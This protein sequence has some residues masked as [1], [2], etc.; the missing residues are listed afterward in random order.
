MLKTLKSNGRTIQYDICGKGLPLVLIHGFAEDNT[1][2]NIQKTYLKEK[3]LVLSI[4]LPGFGGSDP[5]IKNEAE[6][7]DFVSSIKA[8][9]LNE[10]IDTCVMLGHSM[11][12]YVTLAY[13]NAFPGDLLGIGLIH[14]TAGA[15]SQKRMTLRKKSILFIE[16]HGSLAF[17]KTSIPGL[18]HEPY[19]YEK[20]VHSLIEKCANIQGDILIQYY[21]A[22]MKRPDYTELL[23][24]MKIPLLLIAGKNDCI[25]PLKN[26]LCQSHLSNITQF[27]ILKE[28][29]HIGMKEEPKKINQAIDDFLGYITEITTK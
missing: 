11:G 22:I 25:I 27:H 26:L 1:L 13:L 19:R 17:L 10:H 3:Y 24:Q 23:K 9:L 2:W 21:R 14:S 6:L 4:D 5:L 15:D 16:E 12:G 18:F 29:A 20:E 7:S 28:S 8:V